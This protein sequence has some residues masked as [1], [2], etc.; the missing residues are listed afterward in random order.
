MARRRVSLPG[1]FPLPPEYE[2]KARS[3]LSDLTHLR[4]L[5]TPEKARGS[6]ARPAD[7]VNNHMR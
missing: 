4:N 1:R 2:E 6:V 3:R 7:Q 5:L